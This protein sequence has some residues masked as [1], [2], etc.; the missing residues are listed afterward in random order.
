VRRRIRA[1]GALLGAAL[2]N[3]CSMAPYLFVLNNTGR[4]IEILEASNDGDRRSSEL[5][6]GLLPLPYLID[7][8]QGRDVV[9]S[10]GHPLEVRMRIG[11]CRAW[12]VFPELVNTS[13]NAYF[14]VQ[15][16]PNLAAYVVEENSW[17]R[18]DEQRI[19]AALPTQPEGFPVLSNESVGCLSE[20]AAL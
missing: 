3:G 14:V 18:L 2:L 4:V 20:G 6:R 12:Y 19:Q 11:N 16:Q 8:E 15:I 5:D 10:R 9:W 7:P 13:S 1:I 17:R